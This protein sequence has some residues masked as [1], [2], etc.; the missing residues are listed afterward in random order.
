MLF[1]RRRWATRVVEKTSFSTRS[2]EATALIEMLIWASKQLSSRVPVA[3]RV[4]VSAMRMVH[5]QSAILNLAAALDVHPAAAEEALAE[6]QEA[7]ISIA[8][9]HG[10]PDVVRLAGRP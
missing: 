7:A 8:T 2:R 5:N 3:E 1:P 6:L 4:L 10:M 9:E